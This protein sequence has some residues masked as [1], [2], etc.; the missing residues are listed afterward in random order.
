MIGYNVVDLVSRKDGCVYGCDS[1][2]SPS[3]A[4]V[5]VHRDSRRVSQIFAGKASYPLIFSMDNRAALDVRM[6]SGSPAPLMAGSYLDA[7]RR[8]HAAIS[9]LG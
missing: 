2:S 8:D 9:S 7:V 4:P 5:C 1:R 3:S 6:D